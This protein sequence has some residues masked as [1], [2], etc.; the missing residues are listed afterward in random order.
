[1][2]RERYH[3]LHGT[4]ILSR[5]PINSSRIV[6]L[7]L[8]YDWYTQ[9]AKGV[10]K[11]EKGKRWAAH[12]LFRERIQREIRHG[13]RMALIVRVM[14]PELP[15]REAT[16]VAVH[17]ENRCAPACRLRQMQALLA[18]VKEDQNP[19]IFAG[20]LNTTGKNNVPTSLRSEIM[21]RVTDYK[22]WAGQAVSHFHPLGI[23]QYALVPVHCFHAYHDPTAFHLP[24]LWENGE[25]PLFKT[26][27]QFRFSDGRSFDFRGDPEHSL[28]GR[29]RTLADS[30][31][32]AGKGF[33]PTYTFARDYMGL[34]GSLKLDWFFVKP[35]ILD[36]RRNDQS[37]LF[38][39]HLARTMREVNEATK[40]RISDHPPMTVDLPLT[41]DWR[42]GGNP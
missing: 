34:A 21:S 39:P 18:E 13:G 7:P 1:M 19:V 11:L 40:E 31:E 14:I 27:E 42:D 20:D 12:K 4:A 8:C 24:I 32:R 3:G 36:P 25:R 10:A 6:R 16:I 2:D 15:T 33:V 30:D 22:F 41:L 17:L 23:Y 26:V 5:Y 38:A 28:K 9:E 29:K 37:Y 35:F